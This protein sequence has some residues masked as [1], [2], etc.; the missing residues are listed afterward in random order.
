MHTL[1]SM[2]DLSLIVIG[3]VFPVG[4]Y[5]F[6]KRSFACFPTPQIHM[7]EF[8]LSVRIHCRTY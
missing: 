3:K 8:L 4:G 6:H 7:V 1:P 2:Q 5:E